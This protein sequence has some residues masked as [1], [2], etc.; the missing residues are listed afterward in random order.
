LVKNNSFKSKNQ[1]DQL[2]ARNHLEYQLPIGTAVVRV[3]PQ[4]YHPTEVDL[5]IGDP[6]KSKSLGCN[7]NKIWL[8]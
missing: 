8:D 7:P 6:I 3:D 5:L 1:I 4:Y 2:T